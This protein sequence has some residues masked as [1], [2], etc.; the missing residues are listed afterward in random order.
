MVAGATLAV[1]D[2]N[3]AVTDAIVAVGVCCDDDAVGRG[4]RLHRL[5]PC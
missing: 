5:K 1:A 2:A 3:L 4:R